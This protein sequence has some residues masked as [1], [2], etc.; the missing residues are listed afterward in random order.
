MYCPKVAIRDIIWLAVGAK[1][2]GDGHVQLASK[3]RGF[4]SPAE[5]TD[6]SLWMYKVTMGPTCMTRL[7]LP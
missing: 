5:S 7:N 1:R 4:P 6:P 2:A 3:L